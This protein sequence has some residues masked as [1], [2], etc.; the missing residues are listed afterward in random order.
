MLK[1]EWSCSW[2]VLEFEQKKKKNEESQRCKKRSFRVQKSNLVTHTTRII[3]QLRSMSCARNLQPRK[4][5]PLSWY[6]LLP[7]LK[8]QDT[9][10]T[11]F[12]NGWATPCDKRLEFDSSQLQGVQLVQS[13][14]TS[15][16]PQQRSLS[17]RKIHCAWGSRRI[18]ISR[19]IHLIWIDLEV[20]PSQV[21]AFNGSG[22]FWAGW[23]KDICF[24]GPKVAEEF[25]FCGA[26]YRIPFDENWTCICCT[27]QIY[28]QLGPT[29]AYL[30]FQ[31]NII[32]FMGSCLFDP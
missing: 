5:R 27:V 22:A 4:C 12:S 25:L 8:L 19:L 1:Y 24:N 20:F 31:N 9:N 29:L 14:K 26:A 18:R 6:F 28:Q 15:G 16:R 13:F 11:P 21:S 10:V 32:Q 23:E 2:T 30:I 7:P 17:P 3:L